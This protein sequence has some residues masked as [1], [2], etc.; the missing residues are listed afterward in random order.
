[1][2]RRV[3]L[4]DEENYAI[5]P[6]TFGNSLQLLDADDQ[7][8]VLKRLLKVLESDAP[9][10]YIYET[11]SGCEELQ[12]IRAGDYLR[13]LCRLVMGIP[14]ED[15]TYNVL[16]VFFVDNHKYRNAVL[17]RL[18]DAAARRLRILTDFSTVA[19]VDDYLDEHNAKQ[20]EFLRKRLDRAE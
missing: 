1:M 7:R 17:Q 8:Q 15:K 4:S 14:H 18:D 19:D 9:Q 16:F 20:A 5:F 2:N 6:E 13:I 10:R 12:V 11:V 3:S